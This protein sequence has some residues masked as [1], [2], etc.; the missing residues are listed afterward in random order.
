MWSVV[1]RS[2][3]LSIFSQQILLN[4]HQK[5]AKFSTIIV[6]HCNQ[7]TNTKKIAQHNGQTHVWSPISSA[8][9]GWNFQPLL[10]NSATKF[11]IPWKVKAFQEN[12]RNYQQLRRSA[13]NTRLQKIFGNTEIQGHTR[14]LEIQGLTH[15]IIGNTEIQSY[16]RN[17]EILNYRFNTQDNWKYFYNNK[18]MIQGKSEE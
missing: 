9:W 14:Y 5:F 11:Q 2:M 3:M 1:W 10:Y 6:Q 16:K 8:K 13:W 15:K 7:I 4:T 17:L 18:F 12:M